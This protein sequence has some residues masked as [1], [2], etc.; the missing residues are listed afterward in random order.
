M[1]LWRRLGSTEP[2]SIGYFFNIVVPSMKSTY[3]AGAILGIY[4]HLER[5]FMAF[6]G[7]PDASEAD[8]AFDYFRNERR[9]LY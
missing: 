2:M 5:L 7:N 1:K 4:A 3:A 9:L 8:A 6:A